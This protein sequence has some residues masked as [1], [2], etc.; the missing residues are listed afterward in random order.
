MEIFIICF[1]ITTSKTHVEEIFLEV[2]KSN[3][4]WAC[5]KDLLVVEICPCLSSSSS[6]DSL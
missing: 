1:Q 3:K 4:Q 6:G 5:K 2:I